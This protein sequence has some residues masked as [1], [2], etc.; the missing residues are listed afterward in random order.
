MLLRD[1]ARLDDLLKRELSDALVDLGIASWRLERPFLLAH[2]LSNLLDQLEH[3]LGRLM[4]ELDRGD[5]VAL[6]HLLGFAFHHD[7]RVLGR[8]DEE[9]AVALLLLLV[10]GVGDQL[11]IDSGYTNA[12]DG[13]R[14]RDR[15][16]V[17]RCRC[18]DHGKHVGLMDRVRAHHGRDHLRFR[19]VA[20]GKEGAAGTV[21]QSRGQNLVVAQLTLALE[22]T[23]WDLA[24]GIGLFDV[25]DGQREKRLTR[26]RFFVSTYGYQDDR[27]AAAHQYRAGRLLGNTARLDGDC[28]V[29]NL[30]GFSD[31]HRSLLPS[32]QYKCACGRPPRRERPRSPIP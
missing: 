22:E 16:D 13:A 21:D 8:R 23:S 29:T 6:G 19:H 20:L 27:F 18:T 1:V 3:A 24:R 14:P 10:G 32:A 31:Y 17:N 7:D 2:G 4:P 28:L 15:A 5:H 30:N 9:L 12:S 25:V 26:L 11:A